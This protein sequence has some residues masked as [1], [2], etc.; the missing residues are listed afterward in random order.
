M[1]NDSDRVI[2]RR[3]YDNNR[4]FEIHI[5]K[6]KEVNGLK[7]HNLLVKSKLRSGRN[8]YIYINNPV[9]SR[10]PHAFLTLEEFKEALTKRIESQKIIATP[11]HYVLFLSNSTTKRIEKY[12]TA[13][14]IVGKRKNTKSTRK[15]YS[16]PTQATIEHIM[17]RL[18]MRLVTRSDNEDITTA[19]TKIKDLPDLIRASTENIL[20]KEIFFKD[21]TTKIDS[22]ENSDIS[23]ELN[24]PVNKSIVLK[25][26]VDRLF[27]NISELKTLS[28][29]G[30]FNE[31]PLITARFSPVLDSV[32]STNLNTIESAS[33]EGQKE[34]FE[35]DVNNISKSKPKRSTTVAFEDI[36]TFTTQKR[37][38]KTPTAANIN[39]KKRTHLK[40]SNKTSR[41]R[42]TLGRPLVFMGG[43]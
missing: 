11:K 38:D 34:I 12:T 35:R 36:F 40:E 4:L 2:L 23:K 9:E 27:K 22:N 13:A 3:Q 33:K 39:S 30:E 37:D 32:G 14:K 43:Q 1:L 16:T 29:A 21:N 25:E 17:D 5:E 10:V 31:P 7:K 42:S 18:R 15:S 24:I 26:V 20:E 8:Q 19:K 41:K 6:L 28:S